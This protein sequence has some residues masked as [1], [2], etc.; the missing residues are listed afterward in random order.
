MTDWTCQKIELR[1][2]FLLTA[3]SLGCVRFGLN[4]PNPK[5]ADQ[6]KNFGDLLLEFN[7]FSIR[8][9]LVS[10]SFDLFPII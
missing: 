2:R 1:V 6:V 4:N 8:V 7:S 9:F 5:N 10:L 3:F